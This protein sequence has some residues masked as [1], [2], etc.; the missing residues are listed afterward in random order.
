MNHLFDYEL[1][2]SMK[3]DGNII[4]HAAEESCTEGEKAGKTALLK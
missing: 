1:K 2:D 3:H 4:L